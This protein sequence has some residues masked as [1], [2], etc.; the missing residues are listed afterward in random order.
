MTTLAKLL[1]AAVL[2]GAPA[3]AQYYPQPQPYPVPQP[4]PAP[5][6]QYPNQGYPGY[7]YQGQPYGESAIGAIVDSL[8][9]NRYQ[10]SDRQAIRQCAWAAVQRAQGQYGGYPYQGYPQ[11]YRN[12]GR[13]VRV[14]AITDV[15]RRY[16]GVRVRGMLDTGMYGNRPY[17][18][19]YGYGGGYGGGYGQMSFRCDVDYRGYVSNVRLGN[20]YRGY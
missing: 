17:D 18:P 13:N 10:V 9:G 19:R 12:Y 8:I 6:Y 16:N 11:G 2:I 4:Y 5:G 20:G 14:T 15:Q 1:T 3:T 7:Q